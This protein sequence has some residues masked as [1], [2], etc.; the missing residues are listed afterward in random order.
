[1]RRRDQVDAELDFHVEMRARELMARGVPAA[2]ARR[3]A[4]ALL[5]DTVRLKAELT[6]LGESV[7]RRKRWY[8]YMN[9]LWFDARFAFRQMT[10]AK[11]FAAIAIG[12]LA[13]GI[14][15]TTAIFSA[16]QAVVLRPFPWAHPARTMFVPERWHDLNG[17][18]S[19][20][21]YVDWQALTSSFDVL[22]AERLG[23]FTLGA[24]LPERVMGGR[25]TQNY[26]TVF[27]QRPLF[28]RTFRVDEDAPGN[29]HVV[30]LSE[31][32]WRSRFGADSAILG[33]SITLNAAPYTVVGVMPAAFDP[34]LST[35][36]LWVPIAFTPVQRADHD[37]HNLMVFGLL[38]PHASLLSARR[39]L[40]HAA[41][42]LAVRYPSEDVDR[43]ATVY[44][45]S[46]F[47]I[48]DARA[49]LLFVLGAVTFV[50]LIACVNVA[51]LLLAR[52]SVRARELAIRAA[53]GAGR[54]RLVRQLLTES[55]LLSLLA[56]ALGVVLAALL[57]RVLVAAA[58]AGVIPRLAQTHINLTVLGFALTVAAIATFASG[59]L[60]AVRLARQDPHEILRGEG[61]GIGAG[62]ARERLRGALVTIEVTMA[63][64]L[65]VGSGLLVRSA[66][67][68]QR[69]PVGFDTADI[70]SAAVLLPSAT[71]QDPATVRHAFEQI[72]NTLE[73]SGAI[74]HAA[75]VSAKPLSGPGSDNSLIP[76]GRPLVVQNA[77]ESSMRII[78]PNYFATMRIP[79]RR[80]R[81]FTSA[82][83][84]GANR[85]M[86]VSER[87]AQLAWPGADPIGKRVV[88]CEGTEADPMWKTIVGVAGDVRSRGPGGQVDPEFYLPV[89]QAPDDAWTWLGRSMTMVVRS[90]SSTDAVDAMRSAVHS[91]DPSLP[92]F[93]I[94]SANDA[95]RA[96]LAPARFNALLLASLA[97]IGLA[98]SAAGIF[99]VIA[100][101][102]ALRTHE[103]GVRRALGATP[104]DVLW[105]LMRQGIQPVL[106]GLT[107]GMIASL[108]AAQLLRS[109]LYGVRPG[110]IPTFVTVGLTLSLVAL[111]AIL[112]PARRAMR[113]EPTRALQFGG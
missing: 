88:C 104:T 65:L 62:R 75:L 20:G 84:R 11:T 58:P 43:S 44:L 1:M 67:L 86:V 23:N 61:R 87:F 47:L 63:L 29:E 26:F 41:A 15:G 85:V 46:T 36:Q 108:F 101:F 82:D 60:P 25:V 18:V 90:R 106:L 4:V 13:I 17:D 79:L 98:L 53:T 40:Q 48:G 39:D 33:R 77:I 34:S 12:T 91:L 113:I 55:A 110:D 6:T 74:E 8:D 64:M 56:S 28:G 102:V 89:D 30:V 24:T 73:A 69:T 94:Q 42:D 16:V 14:G 37:N 9:E 51:N 54:H 45:L 92:I 111:A 95:F 112:I 31:G 52:A 107:F 71:Y 72:A 2:E 97:V 109:V 19:V 81:A 66:A 103:I 68:M 99:G 59:L 70:S 5:G 80:G 49:Q 10:T 21:N 3:Q 76:E 57:I 22:A 105:L 38:S 96:A 50:F 83:V 32:L 35:E 93:D 7:D 78:T 27:G 100:Y